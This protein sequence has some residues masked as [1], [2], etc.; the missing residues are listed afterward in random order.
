MVHDASAALL[1]RSSLLL[2]FASP[3]MQKMK[4]R[5][6]QKQQCERDKAN[7]RA[8]LRGECGQR[9]VDGV[10]HRWRCV[11]RMLF[12]GFASHNSNAFRSTELNVPAL[13]PILA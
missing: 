7:A 12:M 3:L 8:K 6:W 9:K 4:E 13:Y 2:T 5:L 10:T 11:V 1:T